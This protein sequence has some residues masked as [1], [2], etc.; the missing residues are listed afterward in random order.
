MVRTLVLT[1]L[2]GLGLPAP[3]Q[4]RVPDDLAPPAATN[5]IRG[6]NI[7][8]VKPE[9]KPDASSMPGYELQD[10]AQRNAVQPG[11]NSPMWRGI[12]AGM[13]GT[14]SAPRSQSPEAGVLIQPQAQYPGSRLTTAGEAW[15]QARNNWLI[16]YG[17]ALLLIVLGALGFYFVAKGPIG[18]HNAGD[19][20][21]RIER[22]TPFER[23]AHWANAIAFCVLAISGLVMAFGKFI[24]LPL[25]GLALFGWVSYALKTL[26]DF[27]GPLF[28]V[29]LAVVF[30]TFLRD[31][32]PQRGD[33]AWLRQGGGMFGKSRGHEPPSHRFN[34][35]EKLVFWIGVFALGCLVVASGLVMDQLVPGMTYSRGAMQKAHMTHNIATVLMM[36]LFAGHIYI[37]TIGMRG[38]YTAMRHGWVGDA[39]AAEHHA[40]WCQ[41]VKAG[42]IPMQRSQTRAPTADLEGAEPI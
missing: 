35:G 18:T 32:W 24:L 4:T 15:R 27:A 6:Q 26:H 17:G 3:A 5:G 29:S 28:A 2:L 40:F 31:N 42:K 30:V 10:N 8:D 34:A 14:T 11:N 7:L 41:D 13:E 25:L 16:P 22:F 20:F 39:W 33:W 19:G 37:G 21:G 1:L 12:A 36:C 9:L 38:A 23:S